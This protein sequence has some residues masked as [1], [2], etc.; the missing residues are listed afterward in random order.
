VKRRR[1]R[2]DRANG[3][4]SGRVG[5]TGVGDRSVSRRNFLLQAGQAGALVFAGAA[6]PRSLRA[7][8]LGPTSATGAVQAGAAGDAAARTLDRSAGALAAPGGPLPASLFSGLEWRMLG[9]FRGG[10][11][12]AVTGV[13]GRPNEFYFGHVNGGVWKTVDAGRVWEPVFDS[14]PVA[15]IGAIAVAPSAGDVVYVGSGESTLRD[16]V[17]FGN[18][19]YRSSDAGRTWTHIG[20]GDTQH[21]GKI[22]VHP[23]DPDTVFVAAIGHFYASNPER[24]VF[25]SKDGGRTWQKVLFKEDDVGAIEV[26]ID[27]TNPDVVYAGLWNTRRPPWFVYP[28]TNGP[29]G[30]IFK[31]TDGGDT[32]TQLT[33]GLPAQ[34]IGRT[35]IAVAA[36]NPQRVYALVDCLVPEPGAKVEPPAPGSYGTQDNTPRQGG[37][38]RSDDGGA[39]WNRLSSDLALW[40]RGWYFEHVVVDPTDAD[41]VYVSNVSV[42]RSMDGGKS[43]VP[44]RGSPGG[45]DYHQPWVSP[46]EPNTMIVA[47]D[48]GCVITRNAKTEDPKRV[49]WSS[50]LNQPTAQIYHVS[51]DYRFPYWVTGAQ[52]DSGAVAVRSRGKFGEISMRDWEPIGAGGESGYT[53]GDPLH[54]GI[55]YGGTGSRYVLAENRFIPGTT[56]PQSKEPA[57][58]DWTQ[59]LVLSQADPRA[60]YYG[61]QF[62]YRSRDGAQTWTQISDDLTRPAPGVPSNLDA[63]AAADTSDNGQ[64]GVVYTIAPSPILVPMLWVGTDDGRIQLTTNDGKTWQDVTPKALTAWSRVTMIEASHFDFNSAY[65]SVDRHQLQDFEPYI[66]R[67][68]DMGRTWQRISDGLPAGVYVH[69][70]KEDPER[71]GLLFAGTER[72]AY[73]SFDDGDH[74][75]PLQ[76][77]LPVTSVRDFAVYDGDLIVA[78]HGRGFWVIDDMSAL[79]QADATIVQADAYLYKPADAIDVDQGGDDGTPLQKDEPQAENPPDGAY[80]D[81]WLKADATGPVTLEILDDKG[82]TLHTFS[83]EATLQAPRGRPGGGIPNTTALWRPEPVPFATSAGMHRAVWRPNTGGRRGFGGFRRR[84]PQEPEVTL[85]GTFTAKL[86]VSG[87]SYTQTFTVRPDPRLLDDG[88][89]ARQ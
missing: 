88:D 42:S 52:Q 26:V 29:G 46:D 30:G 6:L 1:A 71:Q 70:V 19:M 84:G 7:T 58:H 47:S 80:I 44:L 13:P 57:R 43:W 76:L 20:L 48:Q 89:H 49:T 18:G 60:L 64:R 85:P 23:K 73:V 35:G 72:G 79:R 53:A 67:T 86:T 83:G 22:A 11:V 34:G 61:D 40:G 65:A 12:D 75:Q 15:S 36:S 24:G 56:Q 69:V 81:Y 5:D 28:P 8:G 63:A 50:W 62:V 27:P 9:P 32:W 82:T 78:T 33:A 55:V 77:N 66:Y 10:R 21:I 4:G 37:F 87:R 45:D 3:K 17:G 39:T 68:R 41:V 14:Q 25:R 31:S 38:F 16:S 54:P 59:P 2:A 51:V 74:W